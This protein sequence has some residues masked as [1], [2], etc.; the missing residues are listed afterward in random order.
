MSLSIDF[1]LLLSNTLTLVNTLGPVWFVV[2]GCILAV[3]LLSWIV[4]E[5]GKAVRR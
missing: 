3:A 4:S 1:S 5:F 2:V